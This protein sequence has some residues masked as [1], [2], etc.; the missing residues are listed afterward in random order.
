VAAC[1]RHLGL[2]ASYAGFVH[3]DDAVWQAVRR[4]RLFMSDAPTSRAAEEIR[5]LTRGLVKGENLGYGY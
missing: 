4:R 3:H 2:R 5:Q 1:Q